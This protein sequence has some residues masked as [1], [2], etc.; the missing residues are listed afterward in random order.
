MY[1]FVWADRSARLVDD[2]LTVAD[3]LAAS[4][5]VLTVFRLSG[6]VSRLVFDRGAACWVPVPGART[7]SSD[8]GRVHF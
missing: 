8:G 7:A 5:N 4:Q 3:Y 6:G 1:L 2:N